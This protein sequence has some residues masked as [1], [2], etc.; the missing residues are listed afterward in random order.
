MRTHRPGFLRTSAG[1]LL[2]AAVARH[3]MASDSL[4]LP[5]S[6]LSPADTSVQIAPR[7]GGSAEG[8]AMRADGTL[9]YTELGASV[10]YW[11]APD[12]SRGV[13]DM[14]AHA[15]NGLA[16]DALDRLVVCDRT[17]VWRA[18]TVGMETTLMGF[19]GSANDLAL[20]PEGG[21]YVTLPVWDGLGSV[22]YRSP[23]GEARVVLDSLAGAPNGIEYVSDRGRVYIG[24]TRLGDI[25]QYDVGP[26]GSL[27]EAGLVA[28]AATPDGMALDTLGNL[29][30]ANFAMGRIDVYDT[31]GDTLGFLDNPAFGASVQNCCF[32]GTDDSTLYIAAEQ[33]IYKVRTQVA[34]RNVRGGLPV[35]GVRT[36]GQ[37]RAFAAGPARHARVSRP[38]LLDGRLI[39]PADSRP[40]LERGLQ[41]TVSAG[42]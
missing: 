33:G 40:F 39:G 4:T 12:G 5:P 42:H 2:L 1:L 16:F 38:C 34:G 18:D 17:R 21:M 37:T 7:S 29:W 20:T 15:P 6:L 32:G 35:T 14:Y 31:L 13:A 11:V 9:F 24:F 22:Q 3:A 36:A 10:I 25:R 28:A 19:A 30:V 23:L 26:D 8:P 27:T 41:A